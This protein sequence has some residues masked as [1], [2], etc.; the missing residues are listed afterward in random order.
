MT[1]E[2]ITSELRQLLTSLGLEDRYAGRS[3]R[4]GATTSAREAGLKDEEIQ[5]LGRWKSNVYRPY[6]L[7]QSTL[8]AYVGTSI[9]CSS[10]ASAGD[11]RQV[12]YHG[13]IHDVGRWRF[14]YAFPY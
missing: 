6:L 10:S 11:P 3:F 4:R 14:L 7:T 5:L 12:V 13:S 8:V 2:A 1:R 9:F